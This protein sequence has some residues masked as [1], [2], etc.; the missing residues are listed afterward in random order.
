MPT[1]LEVDDRLLAQA[2]KLGKHKTKAEA[3][4]AALAE[5]VERRG[6]PRILDMFGK[7]DYWEDYDP[8]DG[9]R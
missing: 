3:V 8:K 6:R 7:V 4:T 5:Y 2:K 1:Q 9:R